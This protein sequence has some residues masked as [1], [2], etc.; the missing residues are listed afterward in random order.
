MTY[1]KRHSRCCTITCCFSGVSYSLR[2]HYM[3][4]NVLLFTLPLV[5]E[6][7]NVGAF[8]AA[9]RYVLLDFLKWPAR[10][11]LPPRPMAGI[12][13]RGR[14][15]AS[16]TFA[17]AAD[18]DL[19]VMRWGLLCWA[20]RAPALVVAGLRASSN[21]LESTLIGAETATSPKTAMIK[22]ADVSACKRPVHGNW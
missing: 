16:F 12:I 22:K 10:N 6:G 14:F 21:M 15:I 20:A 19:V 8:R 7:W 17:G 5:P 1:N 3:I 18:R 2:L 4:L 9:L 11:G 13:R